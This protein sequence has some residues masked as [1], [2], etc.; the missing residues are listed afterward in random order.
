[1]EIAEIQ[2]NR[3]IRLGVKF[4]KTSCLF[5]HQNILFFCEIVMIWENDR[6]LSKPRKKFN[7][8]MIYR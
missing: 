1:M 4:L 3:W 5:D 8:L 6:F 2:L 7:T